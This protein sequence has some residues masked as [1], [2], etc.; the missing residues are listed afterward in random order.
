[1]EVVKM[2]VNCLKI[3]V[4]TGYRIVIHGIKKG[5]RVPTPL[6]ATGYGS[7]THCEPT[8]IYLIYDNNGQTKDIRIDHL[9]RNELR[10]RTGKKSSISQKK[11]KRIMSTMPQTINLIPNG[12]QLEI[13]RSDFLNWFNSI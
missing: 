9:F 5:Q 6:K 7:A 1:M 13:D 4:F 2:L 11:R 10:S 12:N 3:E 8:E